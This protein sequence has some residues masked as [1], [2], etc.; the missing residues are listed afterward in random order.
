MSS[1]LVFYVDENDK[2]RVF[3]PRHFDVTKRPSQPPP[4]APKAHPVPVAKPAVN[5][6][7]IVAEGHE[8]PKSKN[9]GTPPDGYKIPTPEEANAISKA[10]IIVKK[11]TIP[12]AGYGLFV[13][14]GRTIA[15]NERITD[16]GGYVLP[17]DKIADSSDS[18]YLITDS[19]GRV[20]DGKYIQVKHIAN[21]LGRWINDP[22]GT[23]HPPNCE[24]VLIEY[25]KPKVARLEIHATRQL[26]GGEEIFLAYGNNYWK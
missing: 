10:K 9:D 2:L 14:P 7:E 12:N 15:K 24:A 26:K 3:K 17:T 11:S 16:Y 21:D 19:H 6:H 13:K 23:S 18:D 5:Y 8:F 22:K 1:R 20:W 4:A 25:G